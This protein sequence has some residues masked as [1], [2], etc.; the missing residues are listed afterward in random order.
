MIDF[1]QYKGKRRLLVIFAPSGSDECFLEQ[2]ELLEDGERA[3]AEREVTV[4]TLVDA[5]S[6]PEAR[7]ARRHFGLPDEQFVLLLIGKDG[8]VKRQ[9]QE[10]V[11]LEDIVTLIDSMPM[12]QQEASGR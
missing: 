2:Q 7:E 1:E 3:L 10:P 6:A 4:I 11:P 9:S 5:P 12:R 8:T